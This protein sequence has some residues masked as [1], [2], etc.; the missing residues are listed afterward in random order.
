MRES[1]LDKILTKEFLE[2]EHIQNKKSLN[3]I[4]KE[5][6]CC[7]KS[8]AIYLN[9]HKLEHLPPYNG[10]KNKE[11][12]G[13]SGYEDISRTYWNNVKTGARNRSIPFNLKIEQI[14]EL[15]LKQNKKCSLSGLDIGF[16][17]SKSNTASLDR[18]DSKKGYEIDNVQWVHKYINQMKWDMSQEHFIEMCEIISNFQ[19]E[20]K[21][22]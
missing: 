14:W 5:I 12:R 16:E 21:N 17:A 11:H 2:R 6:G 3:K 9:L 20:K 7:H 22:E 15:Y 19:K 1:K 8:V 18:I 13:W 4:S 10:L